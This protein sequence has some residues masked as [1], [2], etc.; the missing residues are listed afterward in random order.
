MPR[1]RLLLLLSTAAIPLAACGADDV[2]SPGEGGIVVVV[3]P[4]PPAPT[5]PPPP[6]PPGPTP[7]G[8]RFENVDPADSCP[9]GTTDDGTL[10]GDQDGTV[11]FR[12]CQITG[13]ITGNYT[14]E[15]ID[16]L[17]YSLGGRV[18]VG[19]DV[20]GDG[21]AADGAPGVLTV[22]PGVV[23]IGAGTADYLVV[24]RGSR[25]EAAGTED[26]PIVFTARANL[27]GNVNPN[28]IGL[29]GGLVI[30]GRGPI[31]DCD[32]G[33]PA[34]GTA[35][36]QTEIEGTTGAFYGGD[37]PNDDS[38]TLRYVQVRYPGFEVSTGN[39]LNGI[40]LGGVGD[41]TE[42]SHIQVHNS[43]DDGI[44]WFGGTVDGDH[45][46]FTGNDDDS[47]DIDNGYTGG[48][49]FLI[50]RQR[51]GG[52]DH[53]VESDSRFDNTPRSAP[54]LSNFTFYGGGG[55]AGADN[56]HLLREGIGGNYLN[57][58]IAD[59]VNCVDVDNQETVDDGQPTFNSV[60]LACTNAFADDGDITVATI[61]TLF[62]M[63]SAN[64]VG[65]TVS[66]TNGFVNG[67]NESGVTATD[68][69]AF[70]ADLVAVDYIGAVEEGA[71]EDT[72]WTANW[73][74][75]VFGSDPQDEADPLDSCL[76][77]PYYPGV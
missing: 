15:Q 10:D 47:I 27:Q 43:S 75:G 39:E 72:V 5:P 12:V 32:S 33:N 19:V 7:T 36:C 2:A 29:F 18:D 45:L 23:V 25:L 38:G 64:D 55:A 11:D 49:Q 21:N 8:A 37:Q 67:A 73:T 50:V 22:E 31:N 48:L 34:G 26:Q 1:T 30:L 61:D 42:M 44:E 66:L 71:T 9:M 46:V 24:Q 41:G 62:N 60:V 35:D 6:P 69:T 77:T 68:P 70:D 74:C 16:G 52:G 4:G 54:T 13:T 53:Y 57:G 3:P 76:V 63:G 65:F 40:S 58:I 51:D 20:G 59:K 28:S 14:L 17:V 56:G